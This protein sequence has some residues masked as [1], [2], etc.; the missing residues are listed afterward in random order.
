VSPNATSSPPIARKTKTA[1]AG[2]LLAYLHD[3]PEDFPSLAFEHGPDGNAI[4]LERF[5]HDALVALKTELRIAIRSGN[6]VG[7]TG[8]LAIVI[9]WFML[10]HYPCKIPVTANSQSQLFDVLWSELA[11]WHRCLKPEFRRLIIIKS[12][13]AELV[14]DPK[15]S[16]AVARTARREQPEALQGFHA[17]NIL[18]VIDEASGV[19]DLVFEVAQGSMSTPGAI[20]IMTG[21]PT[22]ARGY[23]FD[24]FHGQR[25]RW[26]LFHVPCAASRRVAPQYAQEVADRFGID[27]NIYRVRVLGEFPT[28]DEDVLIPRHLLEAATRRD[29]MP[30]GPEI[31]GVDVARF[32]DDRSTLCKRR[33]NT[34]TEKVKWWRNK[35]ATQLAGIINGEYILAKSKPAEICVDTIG[36]GAGVYD[37]LRNE[38]ELP[39]RGVNVAERPA[40][41]D[42]KFDRLRDELWFKMKSWFDGL[43]VHIPDDGDLMDEIAGIRYDFSRTTMRLKIESKDSMRARGDR[44]PDLAEALLMTFASNMKSTATGAGKKQTFN[45][46]GAFQIDTRGVV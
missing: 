2:D 7:K 42:K 19:D 41:E 21:N 16:F 12:D 36:V 35:D 18:F 44:S 15:N 9:L 24:A 1:A 38:Y 27:S 13:R 34:I 39:V 5:Q 43:D 14:A 33:G 29:V 23:F 40:I 11:T 45:S 25:E 17:K 28:S 26:R 6:G 32:G 31:W 20:T 8:F 46:R 4:V 22:R 30:T 3:N 10:T 37:Y